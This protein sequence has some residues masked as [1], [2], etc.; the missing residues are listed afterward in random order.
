MY[1]LFQLGLL[2]FFQ[3]VIKQCKYYP[4]QLIVLRKVED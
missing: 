4:G 2:H 1:L 3:F